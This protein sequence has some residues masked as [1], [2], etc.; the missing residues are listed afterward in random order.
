MRQRPNLD[1][2][3]AAE[4]VNGKTHDTLRFLVPLDPLTCPD[5]KAQQPVWLM[6]IIGHGQLRSSNG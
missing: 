2:V 6:S 3:A 5:W 4:P 1:A